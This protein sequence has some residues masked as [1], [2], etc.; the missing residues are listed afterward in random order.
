MKFDKEIGSRMT[1]TGAAL[2]YA[3][4]QQFKWGLHEALASILGALILNVYD[5]VAFH[6]KRQMH[7]GD[8]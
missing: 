6:V 8:Q 3:L 2:G 1:I 5:W 4:N 7:R